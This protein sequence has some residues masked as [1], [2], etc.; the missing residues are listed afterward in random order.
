[1]HINLCNFDHPGA[2]IYKI[3]SSVAV[4]RI[5]TLHS[6]NV[7][8]VVEQCSSESFTSVSPLS[9]QPAG[10]TSV[11]TPPWEVDSPTTFRRRAS[12]IG[13]VL[14]GAVGAGIMLAVNTI[15]PHYAPPLSR[16]KPGK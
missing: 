9:V 7:S 12:Y 13:H 6:V 14:T 10:S 8:G 16:L 15:W 4:T 3:G 5:E 1:M 2:G 11:V